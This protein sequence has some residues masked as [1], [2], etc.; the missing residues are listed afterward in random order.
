M[1]KLRK[2]SFLLFALLLA[3]IA[4]VAPERFWSHSSIGHEDCLQSTDPVV[5]IPLR[6]ELSPGLELVDLPKEAESDTETT[7]LSAA[8]AGA[9]PQSDI[10]TKESLGKEK[11]LP[12]EPAQ[13]IVDETRD[14]FMDY[15]SPMI[16][17][18]TFRTTTH[19]ISLKRDMPIPSEPGI[20]GR[21]LSRPRTHIIMDGDTLEMLA[22][23]Y[24]R[25]PK[26]ATEIYERNR[27]IL[28]S[29]EELTIGVKIVLPD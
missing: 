7:S 25:D 21:S 10:L 4:L 14:S 26:R 12:S 22:R 17:S 24:L 28:P 6:E 1:S 2:Y 9:Y 5:E 19:R 29:P 8:S 23:R 16:P 18:G 20:N 13:P 3:G 27:E 11:W 15:A